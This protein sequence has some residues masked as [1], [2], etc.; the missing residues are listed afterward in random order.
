ME[1][2]FPDTEFMFGLYTNVCADKQNRVHVITLC[3]DGFELLY[4]SNTFFVPRYRA[5]WTVE[6]FC[7]A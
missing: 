1:E 6:V 7:L 2:P 4:V 5:S 3:N